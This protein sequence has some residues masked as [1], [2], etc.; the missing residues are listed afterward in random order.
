MKQKDVVTIAFIVGLSAIFSVVA[1]KMFIST[2]ENR[3][4]KVEVTDKINA[5]FARPDEK[6][7]NKD[8]V[9]PTQNIQIGN[10]SNTN[11]PAFEQ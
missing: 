11:K 6:I 10:G 2:P 4:Q 5:D 1:S 7:F 8:A 3:S 9:N